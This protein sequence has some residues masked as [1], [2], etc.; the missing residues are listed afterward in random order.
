MIFAVPIPSRTR[1][2]LLALTMRR[3]RG[4][5]SSQSSTANPSTR[6]NSRV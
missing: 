1:A 5:G 4:Y 3:T 2:R 6:E